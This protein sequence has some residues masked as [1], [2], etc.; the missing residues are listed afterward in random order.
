MFTQPAHITQR[1]LNFKICSTNFH[2]NQSFFIKNEV[3][4]NKTYHVIYNR[5][6][7]IFKI[8][9][10]HFTIQSLNSFFYIF[11]LKHHAS[12][13]VCLVDHYG[14]HGRD[15]PYGVF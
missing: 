5:P 10:Y 13:D 12:C 3:I 6:Y 4:F 9:I 15:R 1:L 2:P 11:S 14:H 8:F 7:H